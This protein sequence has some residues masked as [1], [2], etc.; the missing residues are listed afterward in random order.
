[1]GTAGHPEVLATLP[2]GH[3]A[4]RFRS[5]RVG[6]K[7]RTQESST[8]VM[9]CLVQTNRS[10]GQN[11]PSRHLS[12]C[13]GPINSESDFCLAGQ[14][15]PPSRRAEREGDSLSLRPRVLPPLGISCPLLS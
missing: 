13:D 9:Q 3:R 5:A 14:A 12:Q 2:G 1:M 10:L 4:E 11:K 6:T 8:L 7:N 15:G